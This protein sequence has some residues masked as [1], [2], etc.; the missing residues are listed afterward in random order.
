MYIVSYVVSN[1]YTEDED[2]DDDD[3]VSRG[4]GSRGGRSAQPH[5][6]S[7][8]RVSGLAAETTKQRQTYN[9]IILLLVI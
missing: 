8:R 2:G 7:T 4:T 9:N 1:N 6:R 3:E 5:S